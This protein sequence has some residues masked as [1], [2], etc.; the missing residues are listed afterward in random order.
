MGKVRNILE[1]KHESIFTVGSD[2][3]VYRA[4]ELMCQKNVGA[5]II[6]DDGRLAGIFTERDYARK[7]ILKGKSSKDTLV[8]ELMTRNPYTVSPET[9]IDDC[10][11]LMNDKQ[12]RH[13]PVLDGLSLVGV[14]SVGDLIRYM[15]EEQRMIIEHLENYITH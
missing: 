14:I 1:S 8:S 6:E 10:M 13:L 15:L 12:I 7:V 4:I 3:T 5:I 11:G 9:T 2:I